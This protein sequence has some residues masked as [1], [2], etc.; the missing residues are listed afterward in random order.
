MLKKNKI[1]AEP[2]KEICSANSENVIENNRYIKKLALQ[3]LVL[4]KIVCSDLNL[5]P[6]TTSTD[7][8]SPDSNNLI[9]KKKAT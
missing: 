3:R 2:E 9:T 1:P 4:N 6:K 5:I 8:D 7:P